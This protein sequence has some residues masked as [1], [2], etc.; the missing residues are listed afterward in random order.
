MKIHKKYLTSQYLASE[1]HKKLFAFVFILFFGS[2][3]YFIILSKGCIYSSKGMVNLCVWQ[4]PKYFWAQRMLATAFHRN[5]I[6]IV[7]S[8]NNSIKKRWTSNILHNK[9]E[10]RICDRMWFKRLTIFLKWN[11]K[12][13]EKFLKINSLIV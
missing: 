2:N 10:Y 6:S 13:T 11:E 8:L 12:S 7:A 5:K 1:S 4:F 3:T 9:S